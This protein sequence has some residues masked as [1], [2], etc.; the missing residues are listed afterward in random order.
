MTPVDLVKTPM[1]EH[2]KWRRAGLLVASLAIW[3]CAERTGTDTGMDTA[4]AV[5]VIAEPMR[6][7][8]ARTR[9][10]AVGTSRALQSAEIHPAAAGEVIAVNFEPGQF[11]KQGAVLVELDSR[12]EKLAVELAAV[13]LADAELLFDRYRRSGDTGAVTATQ[14]DAAKSQ[15]DA[16]RI[17]LDRAQVALDDRFIKAPFTGHVDLTDVDPGDRI[18]ESTVVTTLDDRSS[19]LVHFTVPEVLV[20]ELEIGNVVSLVAWNRAETELAGKVV[21]LGSRID[22]ATRTFVARATVDN[23]SDSLRPGMSFRVS[24]DIEGRAYPVIAET[25]V[26]WGADGAYVWLIV[27]GV[28]ERRNV[29]IVQRRQGRILV[30]G[31]IDAG[32]LVVIEGIQRMRD[33]VPV[34]YETTGLADRTRDESRSARPVGGA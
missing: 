25:A 32:D 22:P 23:E 18:S 6:F 19:L 16:A 27:D 21:E 30:D 24:V 15:V 13:R 1:S 7:E 2:P 20:G 3:G 28:A 9:V 11:V 10:E 5:R 14:L 8:S 31:D 12:D 33:S 34:E 4:E 17:E 26:Q 29:N